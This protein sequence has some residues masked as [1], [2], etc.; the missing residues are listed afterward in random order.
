MG[1]ICTKQGFNQTTVG[2]G[3][4]IPKGLTPEQTEQFL[5]EKF[6]DTVIA[7][8][9]KGFQSKWNQDQF[10]RFHGIQCYI[11]QLEK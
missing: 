2:P 4:G 3:N 5:F 10:V 7:P 9:L 11:R 6:R 8:D 1:I